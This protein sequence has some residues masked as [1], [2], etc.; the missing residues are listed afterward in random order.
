[1]WGPAL[2]LPFPVL[3]AVPC[4]VA[5]A[6]CRL[7][8]PPPLAQNR[9]GCRRRRWRRSTPQ[10]RRCAPPAHSARVR[11]CA[12][13]PYRAARR[14]HGGRRVSAAAH[15]TPKGGGARRVPA[16]AASRC[17]MLMLSM[18][19]NLRRSGAC[20][21]RPLGSLLPKSAPGLGPPL[22]HLHRDQAHPCHICTGTGPT[23]SASAPLGSPLPH[24][25]RDQA[26]PFPHL[27]WDWARRAHI[28]TATAL[29]AAHI[30]L[31]TSGLPPLRRRRA[32][33]RPSS[34]SSTRPCG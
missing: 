11:R 33:R 26:H 8:R 21:L 7:N 29:A 31:I 10:T 14:A 6:S 5:C 20:V 16:L 30:R 27:H 32:R 24:L 15:P 2:F 19:A 17:R 9:C 23:P 28:C 34:P 4:R 13:M 22:P 12:A 3:F 18:L 1:M 25:L